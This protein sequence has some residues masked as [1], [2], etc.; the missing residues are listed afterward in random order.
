VFDN[1]LLPKDFNQIKN[2][3]CDPRFPWGY[4]SSIA[5]EVSTGPYDFQFVHMFFQDHRV[6]SEYFESIYPL[7]KKIDPGALARV[8]ANLVTRNPVSVESG[9]HTDF[10]DAHLLKS[11]VYYLDTTDGVT[12]FEDGTEVE[13]VENRLLVFNNNMSHTST[14]CTDQKVRRVINLNYYELI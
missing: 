14:S 3:V 1:F 10:E 6:I 5:T 2:T 8:K 12:R 11:A 4:S 13:C 9:Y 7:I